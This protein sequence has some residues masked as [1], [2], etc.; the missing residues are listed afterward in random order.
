MGKIKALVSQNRGKIGEIIRFG[1]T[2][3]VSTLA[4]YLFYYIFLNWLNPTVSF[5]IAYLIAM[6]IN[7]VMTTCFTFKVKANKKNALGFVLSNVI[8]YVL[9]ALFLNFFIWIG[10]SKQW[11]PIPMYGVCV[12][13]NFA[14]VKSIIKR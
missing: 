9:C 5:T 8:N 14:I 7:Y 13:I 10:F 4:T 11:A 6:A 12:P 2:G 1:V 3:I